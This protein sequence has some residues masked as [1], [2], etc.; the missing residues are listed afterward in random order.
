VYKTAPDG[1][2]TVEVDLPQ[3]RNA[4]SLQL[5]SWYD[6]KVPVY[7]SNIDIVEVEE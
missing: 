4:I 1:W 5:T 2:K 7:W 3:G 6:G